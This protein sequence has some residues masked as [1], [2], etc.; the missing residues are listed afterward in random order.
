M[1]IIESNHQKICKILN[2]ISKYSYIK[3]ETDKADSKLEKVIYKNRDSLPI[4]LHLF[5]TYKNEEHLC[6]ID[7][8]G[9]YVV[10]NEC[11]KSLSEAA[12]S[13][14]KVR[15]NGWKF[16]K[17]YTNGPS[18]LDVFRREKTNGQL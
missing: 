3:A 4:G 9:N 15:T 17:I 16:W 12:K 7:N 1:S 6:I 11:H 14:T 2:K 18:V 13:V 5:S 8:L 10:N